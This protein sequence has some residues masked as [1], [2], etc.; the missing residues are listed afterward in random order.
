MAFAAEDA[1]WKFDYC[2]SVSAGYCHP[3]PNPARFKNSVA[4][5][6]CR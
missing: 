2:A 3:G 4:A 5:V 1:A 6:Q